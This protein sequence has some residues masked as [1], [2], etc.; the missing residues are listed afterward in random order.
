MIGPLTNIAVSVPL[1]LAAT[2]WLVKAIRWEIRERGR[3]RRYRTRLAYRDARV[4]EDLA[5]RNHLYRADMFGGEVAVRDFGHIIGAAAVDAQHDRGYALLG[6][7]VGLH[8]VKDG[9]A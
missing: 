3:I 6:A 2:F 5:W 9:A 7:T 8:T 4:P 1:V